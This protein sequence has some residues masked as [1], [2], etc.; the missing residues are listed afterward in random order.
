MLI[1][2]LPAGSG[3]EVTE[4][5]LSQPLAPD[6]S[7][8]LSEAF[9]VH[10]LL[11]ICGQ[12]LTKH[13]LVAATEPFGGPEYRPPADDC[14]PEVPGVTVITTR[15][16]DGTTAPEDNGELIG[17]IGWHS[18][19]A[20]VTA[21]NRGKLLYSVEVPE[22]G[23]LT[24]FIDGVATYEALPEALK[25][26]IDG[27]HVVQSWN[28]AQETI[29]KNRAYRRDGDRVLADNRFPD[30]AYPIVRQHPI[31][32]QKSL[33]MPPLWASGIVE[34]PGAEGR[35]LRDELIAHIVQPQFAYWHRY[36]TG[37][38]VAWDNWRFLHAASGTPASYRRTLWSVVIR[39]G[40][41]IGQPLDLNS[42]MQSVA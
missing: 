3:A 21:P 27:L 26:R 25:A 38:V 42:Q 4:V 14:D 16:P 29:A 12:N 5:D 1:Q 17:Q 23:G 18:D 15:R 6:I 30:V 37:D 19:Q 31:S 36:R 33:N 8:R 2:K 11:V 10:G 39:G 24:G 35:A 13:Q 41:Q 9:E 32:G 22:Q 28:H 40:P 20:Y 7:H 34:M